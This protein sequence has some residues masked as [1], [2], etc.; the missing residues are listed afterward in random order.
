MYMSPSPNTTPKVQ[1]S[2]PTAYSYAVCWDIY[3]R[4]IWMYKF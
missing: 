2:D 3:K 1:K 4:E